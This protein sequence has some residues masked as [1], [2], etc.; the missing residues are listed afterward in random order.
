M[1]KKEPCEAHLFPFGVFRICT[2]VC[3]E[4]FFSGD[5]IG[6]KCY[7]FHPQLIR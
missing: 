6:D 4:F 3:L 7:N 2:L 1:K 5:T